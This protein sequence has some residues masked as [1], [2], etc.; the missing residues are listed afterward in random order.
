MHISKLLQSNY[1]ALLNL[2]IFCGIQV[3]LPPLD[4]HRHILQA[5]KA[6]IHEQYFTTKRSEGSSESGSES[7]CAKY[8]QATDWLTRT[9]L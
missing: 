6:H 5:L 2:R 7:L 3:V 4:H 8:C 1:C 9:A